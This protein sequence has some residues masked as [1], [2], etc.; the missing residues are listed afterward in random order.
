MSDGPCKDAS[1]GCIGK[2]EIDPYEVC[3]GNGPPAGK[4]SCG[5]FS[6]V[7]GEPGLWEYVDILIA[8]AFRDER[9]LCKGVKGRL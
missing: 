2:N 3:E 9:L 7:T 6:R 5:L 4:C 8:A 1:S